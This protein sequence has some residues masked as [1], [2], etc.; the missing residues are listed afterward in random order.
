METPNIW[1]ARDKGR[2]IKKDFY[3]KAG[4]IPLNGYNLGE[5]K[6]ESQ[7]DYT[8]DEE[9]ADQNSAEYQSWKKDTGTPNWKES[10][11]RVATTPI[12]IKKE[13]SMEGYL[14][15]NNPVYKGL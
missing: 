12:G 15:N 5:D 4:T 9:C 8:K 1:E 3:Q 2:E 6:S 13:D 14:E 7:T 11:Q 10:G